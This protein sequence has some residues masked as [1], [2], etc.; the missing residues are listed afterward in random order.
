MLTKLEEMYEIT[1]FM[2]AQCSLYQDTHMIEGEWLIY[3]LKKIEQGSTFSS[4]TAL[5]CMHLVM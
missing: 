3:W 5:Y 2:S 1:I 4:V